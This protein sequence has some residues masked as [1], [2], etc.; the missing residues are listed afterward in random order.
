M[1]SHPVIDHDAPIPEQLEQL[2]FYYTWL[3]NCPFSPPQSYFDYYRDQ[4]ARIDPLENQWR[5]KREDHMKT[6]ARAFLDEISPIHKQWSVRCPELSEEL[7]NLI[8]IF[9]AACVFYVW[10][11]SCTW[12]NSPAIRAL[13]KIKQFIRENS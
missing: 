7:F 13:Y 1:D 10:K 5:T 2:Q 12:D 6:A 4:K 11:D 3:N 9:D 8:S